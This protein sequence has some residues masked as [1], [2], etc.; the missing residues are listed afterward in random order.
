MIQHQLFNNSRFCLNEDWP[1][2]NYDDGDVSRRRHNSRGNRDDCWWGLPSISADDPAFPKL[3]YWRGY[4]WGPMAQLT[5]WSLEQESSISSRF[6]TSPSINNY[7]MLAKKARKALSNQMGAMFLNM[8]RKHAHICENYS[9]HKDSKDCTGD[10]FYHWG[11]LAGLL[12]LL[13][14][15]EEE[16]EANYEPSRFEVQ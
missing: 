3:G 2:N 14:D 5:Y 1:N 4:V 16:L 8:W 11:G 10:R 6:P 7:R 12:K 15:E 9:P 13:E